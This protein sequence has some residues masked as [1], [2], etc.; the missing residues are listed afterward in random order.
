MDTL[1][2]FIRE[3]R[4]RFDIHKP[5][6][7]VWSGIEKELGPSGYRKRRIVAVL[8][9]AACVAIAILILFPASNKNKI[10]SAGNIEINET[11]S[12]YLQQYNTLYR[13]A[14]PMLAGQPGLEKELASDMNLLD[15]ILT[16]IRKDLKDN[17]SCPEVIEALIQNYRCRV[18]ILEEMLSILKNNQNEN[19]KNNSGNI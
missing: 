8:S 18:A 7:R 19:E 14:R 5:G 9:A 6:Q 4:N 3:N 11:L 13:S 10:Q 2:K 1:E 15:S 16:D 12:F 17:V